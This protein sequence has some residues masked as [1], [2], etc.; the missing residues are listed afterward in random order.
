MHVDVPALASTSL[1]LAYRDLWI[2][3][4]MSATKTESRHGKAE[5]NGNDGT[6]TELKEW[7]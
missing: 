1:F 3:G 2:L 5:S 7:E 4:F 6:N